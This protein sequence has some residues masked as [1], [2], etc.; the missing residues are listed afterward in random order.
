MHVHILLN[1]VVQKCHLHIKLV[2]LQSFWSSN[3]KH[4]TNCGLACHRAEDLIVINACLL[5]MSFH[6]KSSMKS[7][8]QTIS[9]QLCSKHPAAADHFHILWTNNQLPRVI[10]HYCIHFFLHG[11]YPFLLLHEFHS[12]P[13]WHWISTTSNSSACWQKNV[14]P[15]RHRHW[16]LYRAY[17]SF[18]VPGKLFLG[19]HLEGFIW[20]RW[21]QHC[22]TFLPFLR[23]HIFHSCVFQ[24]CFN[25]WTGANSFWLK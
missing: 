2:E 6:D 5:Y 1:C 14:F 18:C 20:L 17:W 25:Q 3:C 15:W 21:F 8:S 13:V 7:L 9:I 12:F 16:P 11:P 10:F 23:N 24:P 4:S 19:L 22:V